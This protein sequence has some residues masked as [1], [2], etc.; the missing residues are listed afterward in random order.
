MHSFG[1][2]SSDF[3]LFNFDNNNSK[4]ERK[5][6]HDLTKNDSLINKYIFKCIFRHLILCFIASSTKDI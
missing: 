4:I 1:P 6:D 5:L 3:L 2:V